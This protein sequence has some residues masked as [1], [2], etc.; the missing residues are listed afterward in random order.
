[1][2]RLKTIMQ[3]SRLPQTKETAR[4][5]LAE[6]WER[7]VI[8]RT[9]RTAVGALSTTL[10]ATAAE[11][12]RLRQVVTAV[13]AARQRQALKSF[14]EKAGRRKRAAA[15]S[16]RKTA[17][18]AVALR[19]RARRARARLTHK[20]SKLAEKHHWLRK[21]TQAEKRR[22]RHAAA[23]STVTICGLGVAGVVLLSAFLKLVFWEEPNPNPN[24][25]HS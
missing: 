14:K 5:I 25:N 9:G 4:R 23:L 13:E 6:R 12:S 18:R 2:H 22:A 3:S 17:E 16:V 7:S 8:R 15:A 21:R 11:T 19:E 20:R 24:P 10:N 1:M